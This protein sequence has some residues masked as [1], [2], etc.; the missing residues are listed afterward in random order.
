MAQTYF[1]ATFPNADYCQFD[2]FNKVGEQPLFGIETANCI[3]DYLQCTSTSGSKGQRCDI[4]EDGDK[5]TG[6]VQGP[7]GAPTASRL[8]Q[9]TPEVMNAESNCAQDSQQTLQKLGPE[10]QVARR[11]AQE[12]GGLSGCTTV[13]VQNIPREFTTARWIQEIDNAGF[14]GQYD[15]LYLPVRNHANRGFAFVNFVSA[16]VAEKFYWRFH[17]HRRPNTNAQTPFAVMPADVQGFQQ[18]M[19]HYMNKGKLK[20]HSKPIFSQPM[21]S[22]EKKCM[23]VDQPQMQVCLVPVVAPSTSVDPYNWGSLP[24]VPMV[25]VQPAGICA[26]PSINSF[27][28]PRFCSSCGNTRNIAHKFC[29]FCAA[30]FN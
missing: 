26:D 24:I 12:G 30:S 10:M 3:L 13:M 4:L 5:E 14:H 29:P 2:T 9:V 28:T 11:V 22:H 19:A 6:Q 23:A 25:A 15:F 17:G 7:C 18:N 1:M 8:V 20:K 27:H 21:F 16:D